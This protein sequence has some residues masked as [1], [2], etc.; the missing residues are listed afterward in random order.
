MSWTRE[1]MAARAAAELTDG[2]YVNLGIGLPTLVSN[3]VAEGVELVLQSENGLLGI[4]P[5]PYPGDEDPDLIN[6]GKET[7]TLRRGASIFD[8]ATSF[9][10][11]R[12]GKIDTAILGAMQVSA[13]G[14]IANWTIPGKMI[15]GMGGAM[16][17]ANG[18]KRVIVLMEHVAK[19]GSYKI[20]KECSLPYTG[21]KSV[22]RIITDLGVLDVTPRG[23]QLVELAADV[24]EQEMR[25]KTEPAVLGLS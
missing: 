23:L 13:T 4:G 24:S 17:I 10:M 9:G 12:G 8:S 6:A 14:D 16:D 22:H 1:Q 7:V 21:R 5:Y 19:D 25:N 2:S 11:I 15:K 3:Y 20:V 18:A